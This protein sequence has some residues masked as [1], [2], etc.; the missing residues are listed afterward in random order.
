L[1]ASVAVVSDVSEVDIKVLEYGNAALFVE[2][3]GFVF[4]DSGSFA[5]G[6]SL[7]VSGFVLDKF[8]YAWVYL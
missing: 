5:L 6:L 1:K 2:C 8:E 7:K 3:G 4:G